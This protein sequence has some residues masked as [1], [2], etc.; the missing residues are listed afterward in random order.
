MRGAS[1]NDKGAGATW[2]LL[3][4][5]FKKTS[6]RQPA[7]YLRIPTLGRITASEKMTNSLDLPRTQTF[8]TAEDILPPGHFSVELH[9][10]T[11]RLVQDEGALAAAFGPASQLGGILSRLGNEVVSYSHT[12]SGTRISQKQNR[13]C[14]RFC[15]L[16]RR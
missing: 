6:R 5:R 16:H 15:R 12:C 10:D 4:S 9:P 14:M 11:P 8:Q 7:D 13:F 3:L 1:R 2:A